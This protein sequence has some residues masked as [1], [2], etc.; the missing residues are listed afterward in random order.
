MLK[1]YSSASALDK[2]IV[3]CGLLPWEIV[4]PKNVVLKLV[5]DFCVSTHP[6]QSLST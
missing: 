1:A 4:A 2:A 5:V 3:A 6:A